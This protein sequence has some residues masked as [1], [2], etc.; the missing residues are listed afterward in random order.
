[1]PKTETTDLAVP[2]LNEYALMKIEP[3]QFREII[4]ANVGPAGFSINDLERITLPS[5]G[6]KLWEVPNLSGEIGGEERDH[7]CHH[8]VVRPSGLLV[9]VDGRGR[10]RH[11]A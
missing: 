1:M 6:G 4:E 9:N 8:R 2:V 5:G 3:E 7:R 11:A 10:W